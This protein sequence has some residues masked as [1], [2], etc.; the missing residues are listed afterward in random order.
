MDFY[1]LIIKSYTSLLC[2]KCTTEFYLIMLSPKTA[3]SINHDP[4]TVATR[5]QTHIFPSLTRFT[6]ISAWPRI[7]NY[8]LFPIRSPE[9]VAKNIITSR[10]YTI[11]WN[12][13][14]DQ[15]FCYP[16]FWL[17][18]HFL[19]PKGAF[20]DGCLE[21]KT[22]SHHYHLYHIIFRLG[23]WLRGRIILRGGRRRSL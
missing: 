10:D 5:I 14:P 18:V 13:R 4:S 17:F 9:L 1:V 16:C 3:N 21:V 7:S 11:F 23:W 2:S 15:A 8:Y 20:S 22:S 19:L 12:V 6:V